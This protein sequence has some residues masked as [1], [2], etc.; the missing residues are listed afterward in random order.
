MS[1]LTSTTF[2]ATQYAL[3]SSFYAL[4]GKLLGGVSGFLVDWFSSHQEAYSGLFGG[5]AGV[6][7]KTVGY[8]PFFAMTA[9]MGIPALILVL[10]V[11]YREGEA[12]SGPRVS[13]IAR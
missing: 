10:F 13:P 7:A 12:K 1:S 8:V 3:F 4:P 2:T 9:S 6:S 5:L 11:Y